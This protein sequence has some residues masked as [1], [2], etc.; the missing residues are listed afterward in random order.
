MDM[1]FSPLSLALPYSRGNRVISWA[2]FYICSS[3]PGTGDGMCPLVGLWHR[4]SARCRA[5]GHRLAIG[6]GVH[7]NP[8]FEERVLQPALH[9]A[10]DSLRAGRCNV[11]IV[12][13]GRSLLSVTKNIV[14]ETLPCK[15]L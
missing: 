5:A 3:E 8:G 14:R 13:V 9:P 4:A 2:C 6:D 7:A 12:K 15:L 10:S 1:K 11:P